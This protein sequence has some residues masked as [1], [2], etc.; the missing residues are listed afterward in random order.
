MTHL[1]QKALVVIMGIGLFVPNAADEKAIGPGKYQPELAKLVASYLN[2]YHYSQLPLDNVIAERTLDLYLKT[3]DFNRMFFL[4]SDIK[5]FRSFS[6]P[7][8]KAPVGQ[9]SAHRGSFQPLSS[10]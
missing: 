10:R 5:S 7:K 4:A 9:A 1:L 6:S 3:L 8:V 2:Y